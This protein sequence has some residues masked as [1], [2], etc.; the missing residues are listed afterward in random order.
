MRLLIGGLPYGSSL[1][2][3]KGVMASALAAMPLTAGFWIGCLHCKNISWQVPFEMVTAAEVH[4]S[5]HWDQGFLYHLFMSS[6][7]LSASF[8]LTWTITTAS[9]S[10]PVATALS[11]ASNSSQVM[12]CKIFM[13][14][15]P[16]VPNQHTSV[17]P[18]L[19]YPL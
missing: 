7:F 17:S 8:T 18:S 14:T 6:E 19:L 13:V 10:L 3:I 2:W 15:C 5:S 12:S 16:P 11:S 1:G 9:L 4:C